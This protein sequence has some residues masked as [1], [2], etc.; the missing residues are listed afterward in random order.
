M[1]CWKLIRKDGFNQ[2]HFYYL[3]G[4][5]E[6]LFALIGYIYSCYEVGTRRIAYKRVPAIPLYE[7][8]KAIAVNEDYYQVYYKY[9]G[10]DKYGRGKTEIES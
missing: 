4:T 3:N 2:I 10:G 7:C 8:E 9:V 6:D 1:A 5:K